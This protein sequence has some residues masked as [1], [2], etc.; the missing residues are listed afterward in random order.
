[1][2]ITSDVS[3]SN[4]LPYINSSICQSNQTTHLNKINKLND[5]SRINGIYFSIARGDGKLLEV[6]LVKIKEGLQISTSKMIAAVKSCCNS[7]MI[8]L[9]RL[10]I[11]NTH[12]RLAA[13][14]RLVELGIFDFSGDFC[15]LDLLIMELA[16]H[17]NVAYVSASI[18]KLTTKPNVTFW[19]DSMSGCR[20]VEVFNIMLRCLFEYDISHPF[21]QNKLS[22]LVESLT[23]IG[24]SDMILSMVNVF[25]S[26]SVIFSNVEKVCVLRAEKRVYDLDDCE[27]LVNLDYD[28]QE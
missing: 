5:E 3:R 28:K 7:K 16:K 22:N 21:I 20:S 17:E 2:Q 15:N 25:G 10:N 4:I 1:M 9:I 11:S 24:R 12:I 23:R 14:I 19:I 8:N 27:L 13:E 26:E 18:N 6:F